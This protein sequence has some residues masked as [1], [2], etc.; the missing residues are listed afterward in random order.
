MQS[1]IPVSHI[2]AGI[3][4]AISWKKELWKTVWWEGI[5]GGL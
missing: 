3:L 1:N 2:D 4:G 5:F